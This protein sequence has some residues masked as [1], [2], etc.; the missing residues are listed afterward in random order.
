MRA[1]G[2]WGL[3]SAYEALAT[4]QQLSHRSTSLAAG[5]HLLLSNAGRVATTGTSIAAQLP[6]DGRRRS[7]DQASNLAQ[8][9]SLGAADLN[10]G[11]FFNTE[12]G[13][14][15]RGGTAPERSGVAI[16][17]CRRPL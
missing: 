5:L 17:F 10:G 4:R 14:R 2:R 7:G 3:W 9:E 1:M 12:F 11:A 15:H 8:P 16:S 6:A 13:I